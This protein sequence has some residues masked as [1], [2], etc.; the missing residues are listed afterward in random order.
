MRLGVTPLRRGELLAG[1]V[2]LVLVQLAAQL[3]VL[4]KPD[5][6]LAQKQ[7]ACRMLARIGTAAS[8]SWSGRRSA[9]PRVAW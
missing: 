8:C 9:A 5:A 4:K 7:E 3:A 2:L 1:K 6:T